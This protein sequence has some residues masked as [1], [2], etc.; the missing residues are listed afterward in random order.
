MAW[1]PT[2]RTG[3][4]SP[5]RLPKIQAVGGLLVWT[6]EA[7]VHIPA[8]LLSVPVALGSLVPPHPAGRVPWSRVGQQ[9][10]VELL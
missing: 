7:G 4:G 10:H 1:A 3:A 5:S 2:P 6:R 9:H 8:V